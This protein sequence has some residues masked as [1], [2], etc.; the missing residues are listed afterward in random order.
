VIVRITRGDLVESSHVVD[1]C[2]TDARGDVLLADGDIER[3]VFLRSAAK[4]FIAAAIVATGA[5]DRFA[6]DARELAV[7][8]ASHNGEPI[9]VAA[10]RGILAK[11]GLGV[12]AL[13]C[14]AH[15]PAF[16]PA[17]AALAAAGEA[18]SAL[19]NNCSGKHAGILAACVHLGL[20]PAGYLSAEHP[21]QRRILDL[22]ARL[23]GVPAASLPLAVDGCGIPVYAVSLRRA[24]WSFARLAT[25]DG[26]GAADAAA[27]ERV[28]AAMRTEPRY[29]AG[30]GR[31]D[32]ALMEATG[33]RI[34]CKAGAEGVHG[35]AL[36]REGLGLVLKVRDGARRA[37]APAALAI[38]ERLGALEP[39]EAAALGAFAA[40]V[41]HN[42]AGATVGR[43]EAVV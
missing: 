3:P 11:I 25:L 8:A 13:Q 30:T 6:F 21:V 12:E 38:C 33:G 17:A 15:A 42:V 19:H 2:V 22:C 9:H 24:A 36:L 27:L 35:D 26:V 4:P 23:A 37:A 43:V 10:V 32:T 1:F 41:V 7:I 16:E 39:G 29:V 28:R 34:V 31:F 18:P 5:A 40:P 14:G 20:D